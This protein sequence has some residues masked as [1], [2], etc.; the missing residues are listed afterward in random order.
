MKK[1]KK[2]AGKTVLLLVMITSS[3]LF[4]SC[5]AIFSGTKDKIFINTTPPNADVYVDGKLLGKSGQDIILKRRYINTR[6]VN[7][8]L[9]GYEDMNF[10]ID[11]EIARA[12]WLNV[13][14]CLAFVVPG[15]VGFIVD[16]STGA[17]LKPK[18]TEFNRVLIPKK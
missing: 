3:L 15:V 12:Y 13:P 16:I 8:R 7:L 2:I 18:A 5:A 10:G 9:E 17:A 1:I 4:Q 6:E 11:Q 14:F